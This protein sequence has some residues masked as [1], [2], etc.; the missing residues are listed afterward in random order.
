MKVPKVWELLGIVWE[1]FWE[2]REGGIA[3]KHPRW[4]NL[5]F[6][7]SFYYPPESVG[8]GM[9]RFQ[10]AAVLA[11]SIVAFF[12][13]AY[14]L[15][16]WLVKLVVMNVYAH[17]VWATFR[18]VLDETPGPIE[19]S[20]RYLRGRRIFACRAEKRKS[21]RLFPRYAT[22]EAHGNAGAR[23]GTSVSFAVRTI[24]G[25]SACI[26]VGGSWEKC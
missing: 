10:Q 22:K 20:F 1:S 13:E 11:K 18:H 25:K 23:A 14:R 2:F 5:R 4:G 3:K 6:D 12:E 21:R 7:K 26:G 8:V 17:L 19:R 9:H 24:C 16:P 15:H